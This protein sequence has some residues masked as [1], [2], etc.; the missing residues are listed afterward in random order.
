[1]RKFFAVLLV[2]AVVLS[3]SMAFADHK[4]TVTFD[5]DLKDA[6]KAEKAELW[7]PYPMMEHTPPQFFIATGIGQFPATVVYSYVGGMLTRGGRLLMTGLLILFALSALAVLMRQMYMDYLPTLQGMVRQ[8]SGT[9]S[10][11]RCIS[12]SQQPLQQ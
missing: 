11:G 1:M 4:G 8:K 7:L 10:T 12:F 3:C 5:V 6:V 2:L 9:Q